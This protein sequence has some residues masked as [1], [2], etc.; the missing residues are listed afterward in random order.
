MDTRD[1]ETHAQD[2]G[3]LLEAE[4]LGK[5]FVRE[6]E[7]FF[8]NYHGLSGKKYRVLDVKGPNEARRRI[9]DGIR[10]FRKS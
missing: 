1:S 3:R 2:I 10:A 5:Q 4:D 8:V 7:D 6:L 9:K